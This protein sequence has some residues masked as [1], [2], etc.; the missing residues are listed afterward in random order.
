[1]Y[2]MKYPKNNHVGHRCIYIYGGFRSHGGTPKSSCLMGFSIKKKKK[3]NYWGIPISGNLH[4]S[5][6]HDMKSLDS[7]VP[8][9]TRIF[10]Y[11][12]R[13]L[14]I[15]PITILGQSKLFVPIKC[16][17]VYIYIYKHVRTRLFIYII[18]R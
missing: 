2:E 17:V 15:N 9:M 7:V 5:W 10:C 1:M 4:T 12:P 14:S 11:T 16:I 8:P 18:Y 3:T 6:T 13:L